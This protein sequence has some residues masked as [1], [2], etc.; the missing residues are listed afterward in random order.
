MDEFA[1]AYAAGR[2]KIVEKELLSGNALRQLAE[3]GDLSAAIGLLK[4]TRYGPYLAEARTSGNAF[5]LSFEMALRDAYD[6]VAAYAGEPL[7]V[8][9]FRA[10]HDFHNVKV[11]VKRRCL[12]IPEGEEAFSKVGNVPVSELEEVLLARAEGDPKGHQS[13][14]G[15]LGPA[16]LLI[17][18]KAL[19]AAYLGAKDL[20]GRVEREEAA[21]E[22]TALALLADSSVDRSYY[23]WASRQVRKL[24]YPGLV[25]FVAAE[26]DLINLRMAL[27]AAKT[28]LSPRLFREIVLVGGE[29]PPD[30]V[31]RAFE[32]G[33]QDLGRF[34]SKTAL[35]VLAASGV[36]HLERG[37]SL[38]SWEKRCDDALTRVY[39]KGRYVSIG[40]EPVVGYL[41]GKEAEV[42]NLR[43][44]FAGKES[45]LA[46]AEILERL[47]ETYV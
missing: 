11:A 38:T 15:S 17:E 20:I 25:E 2:I 23:R 31:A 26:V 34:Y 44:V 36:A 8:T 39:R 14:E 12:G 6:S 27:R 24:S 37:E 35:A 10:R 1:W 18:Q 19:R 16:D 33:L 28:G 32:A 40:P 21:L 42:R 47:R 3:A 7:A 41:L 9:I 4:D 13:E 5:D 30:L 22:K 45:G 43:V 29:I 46:P